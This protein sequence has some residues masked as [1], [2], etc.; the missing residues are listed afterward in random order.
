[1]TGYAIVGIPGWEQLR[2]GEADRVQTERRIDELARQTVPEDVPRDRA[3]P[4]RE[5]TRRHLLRVV[6]QG[7]SAGAVIVCLPTA[8]MGGIAVPASYTVSEWHDGQSLDVEPADVVELLADRSDVNASVV[9]VD[10]QPAL[11]EEGVEFPAADAHELAARPAR[12]VTYTIA[13]P[14]VPGTWV[15]V[16]FSTLGD[17]DPE[18]DLAAVLVE[19]FDAHIGTLRWSVPTAADL[20]E[21]VAA[22]YSNTDADI[23]T[24]I[25]EQDMMNEAGGP[26]A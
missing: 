17:G 23:D 13:D 2:L 18:G 15:V 14:V 21:A 1:M 19:L 10:G 9:E 11:R 6:D 22:H 25:E 16:V 24:D 3:T 26:G 7:R 12:R 4:F 20:R 5:E 8:R